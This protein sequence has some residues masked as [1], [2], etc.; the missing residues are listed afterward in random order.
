MTT[1]IAA[2][3]VLGDDLPVTFAT[4]LGA[5]LAVSGASAKGEREEVSQRA[6]QQG[7]RRRVPPHGAHGAVVE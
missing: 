1:D 3:E 5:V 2:G 6:Q 4:F 7:V